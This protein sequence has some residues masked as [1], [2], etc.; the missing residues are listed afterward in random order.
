M[1]QLATQAGLGREVSRPTQEVWTAVLNMMKKV[2]I[3]CD[4]DEEPEDRF[5]AAVHEAVIAL[6]GR[7]GGEGN[8]AVRDLEDFCARVAINRFKNRRRARD[9]ETR[10]ARAVAE[11]TP[12]YTNQT[13]LEATLAGEARSLVGRAVRRLK[14]QER[15]ILEL[16]HFEG[17]KVPE[18]V[19]ALGRRGRNLTRVAVAS[20]LK[21]ARAALRN[22]LSVLLVSVLFLF[23]LAG[24]ALDVAAGAG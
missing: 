16:V 11:S 17:L 5:Q 15:E 9:R 10:A 12:T 13:P 1:N 23:P 7:E 8:E 6:T 20:S 21:R 4:R 14:P 24:L 22:E 2:Y 19:L 18:V 3:P